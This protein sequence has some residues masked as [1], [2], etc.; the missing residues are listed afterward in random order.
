MQTRR[1]FIK[2]TSGGLLAVSFAGV[3]DSC[4]TKTKQ[5][6][7]IMIITDD[8]GYGDFGIMGNPIIQTPHIDSMARRSSQMTSFYVS[9][10][11]A[12]TRACL[13]T[14]RYN[15]RTRAIDTYIGRAMM[16]PEET[17]I[18]EFLNNTFCHYRTDAFDKT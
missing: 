13:M 8:Q 15:Y 17:T 6:N 10:V 7:V 2:Q 11:C 4:A 16:D 1:Q 18:A 3:L 14:G 12:P 5:P 9:P